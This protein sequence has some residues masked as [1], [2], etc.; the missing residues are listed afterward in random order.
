MT[1]FTISAFAAVLLSLGACTL[2]NEERSVATGAG[3]GAVAG[4]VLAGDNTQGRGAV[5]G[6]TVGAL[7]GSAAANR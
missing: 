2:T 5:V 7:V 3:I 4:A 6:A 1:K